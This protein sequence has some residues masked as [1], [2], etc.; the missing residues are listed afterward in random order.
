MIECYKN[1]EYI[2]IYIYIYT[3]THTHTYIDPIYVT[4]GFKVLFLEIDFFL[5]EFQVID[6]VIKP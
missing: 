5:K 4:L 3:H 2:Y 6:L 1:N